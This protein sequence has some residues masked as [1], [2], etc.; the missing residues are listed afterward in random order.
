MEVV[1]RP[2]E[3]YDDVGGCD[4]QIAEL[5]EAVVLPMTHRHLFEKL[6]IHPPKGVLLYGPPGGLLISKVSVPY[7]HMV[8]LS[9]TGKTMLARAVAAETNS[10]FLKLAATQLVQMYIG[11]GARLVRDAFALAREKAPTIIFI[12]ELDAV[13]SKRFSSSKSG[14]REAQRTL[15]ELLSQL[16]GFQQNDNVKVV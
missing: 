4:K 10:T 9:G 7:C 16:D 6:G 2:T 3:T 14:D 12:D 1:E 5:Q 8:W 13:G 15:L 11:D